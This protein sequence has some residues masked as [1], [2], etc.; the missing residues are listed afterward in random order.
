MLMEI[1]T[2]TTWII[3]TNVIKEAKEYF[4]GEIC[5][6]YW[7][8]AG[9]MGAHFAGIKE[10]ENITEVLSLGITPTYLGALAAH[11][12]DVCL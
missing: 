9:H 5:I 4:W 11:T 8:G 2:L 1:N 12:Q 10:Q 6:F 7:P 3:L